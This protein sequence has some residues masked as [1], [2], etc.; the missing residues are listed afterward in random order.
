[1]LMKI[2]GNEGHCNVKKFVTESETDNEKNMKIFWFLA[3][4]VNMYS[5]FADM[6]Y[7][8]LSFVFIKM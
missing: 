3:V 7:L 5:L 2:S 4:Y 8:W 6:T 1:M